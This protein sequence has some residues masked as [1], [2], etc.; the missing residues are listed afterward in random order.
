MNRSLKSFCEPAS[1]EPGCNPAVAEEV[2]FEP[3]TQELLRASKPFLKLQKKLGKEADA[4]ARRHQ[5]DR[6]AL[7]KQHAAAV[8]KLVAAQDKE[9]QQVEKLDERGGGAVGGSGGALASSTK[10]KG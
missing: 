4:L 6:A 7:Q 2:G 5:K 10:N 9:R 3:L 8:D 1:T